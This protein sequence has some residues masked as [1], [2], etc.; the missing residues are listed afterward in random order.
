MTHVLALAGSLRAASVHRR[1]LQ[2]AVE[3]AP[4]GLEIEIWDGLAGLPAYDEDLEDDVPETVSAFRELVAGADALLI[5][6][7]EYNGSIPGAL[8][9]AVDWAS[10]PRGEAALAGIPVALVSGSPSAFGGVWAQNELRKSLAIAGAA[11]L[12]AGV[13][14]GKASERFDAHG[15]LDTETAG[16]LQT[17]LG[18]LTE[19]ALTRAPV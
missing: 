16:Q 14:V 11:P 7:P 5:V 19:A 10:R 13:A 18:A 17:L 15:R 3:G 8:K 2:A 9:N 4:D 6:T 1:L 12:E